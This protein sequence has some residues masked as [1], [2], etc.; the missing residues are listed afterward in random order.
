MTIQ[1]RQ[2]QIFSTDATSSNGKTGVIKTTDLKMLTLAI[3]IAL[4]PL[5][6]IFMIVSRTSNIIE[7]EVCHARNIYEFILYL[8]WLLIKQMIP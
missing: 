3:S 4:Y 7:K 2:T 5:L 1:P 8:V 6:L